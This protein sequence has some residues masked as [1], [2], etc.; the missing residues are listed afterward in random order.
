MSAVLDRA[1][2]DVPEA[3]ARLGVDKLT[4]Y[5]AIRAGRAPVPVISV[6]RRYVIP[7]AALGRL[8]QGDDVDAGAP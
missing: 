7:K 3:A 2:Y 1:T 5:A 6:G 8:L 4:L